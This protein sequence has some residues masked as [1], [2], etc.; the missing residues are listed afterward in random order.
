MDLIKAQGKLSMYIIY[1]FLLSLAFF[2]LSPLFFINRKKYFAGLRERL[3]NYPPFINDGLSVIWLH[4]VSVGEVNAAR[5]LVDQSLVAFPGYRLIVSTTTKTGQDHA[6]NVF[7]GKAQAVFYLPFDWKFSVRRAL[8]HF[9]PS[10]LLLMET[11]VWPR[12]IH[13]AKLSGTKVAVV[14]GRMSQR[15]FERYSMIRFFLSR[16]FKQI[17]L[18]LMQGEKDAIRV[19]DLGADKLKIVTTGNL[20]FDFSSTPNEQNITEELRERFGISKSNSLIV[21]ASTH[22]PEERIVTEAFCSAANSDEYPRPRLMIAPRHPERFA[23]VA[24]LVND[25]KKDPACEWPDYTV[26]RRSDDPAKTDTK[27][28]IIILDSIG[29]LRAVYPLASIVFVGGSLIPH[30]G[31]S[32][33]EPA[34]AGKPIIIGPHFH[35]F[36]DAVKLF[37]E[38]NALIRLDDGSIEKL[39][40]DLFLELSDLLADPD[41]RELLGKNAATVMQA[42][43]GATDKTISSLKT[44][45]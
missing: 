29:E 11:E 12:L 43:R 26:A 14:N 32:I 27:A 31:Q 35:N 15:S 19:R 3:G 22:D 28:D 38:N 21:A 34:A 2:F 16:A 17:D 23:A 1:S 33:L 8:Q 4:C 24:K 18:F 13:E 20:K 30:G 37:E 10:V 7:G 5:S 36:V 41:E 6:K 42:N 9:K 45:L 25:F 39:T 40:D 44:L